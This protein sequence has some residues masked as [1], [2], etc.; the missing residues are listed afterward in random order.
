MVIKVE[1]KDRQ[2][3][4]SGRGVV[5]FVLDPDEPL[6]G[7]KPNYSLLMSG[8]FGQCDIEGIAKG[9]LSAVAHLADDKVEEML[10][11]AILATYIKEN[12]AYPD[13][14]YPEDKEED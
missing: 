3:T 1:G 13:M 9:C 7:E 12:M 14:A 2:Y 10:Y 6:E 11:K 4:V 8:E 5:A